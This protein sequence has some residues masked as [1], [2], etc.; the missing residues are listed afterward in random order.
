MYDFIPLS[1]CL[2]PNSQNSQKVDLKKRKSKS[3]FEY[4]TIGY[5]Q[6]INDRKSVRYG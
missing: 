1:T 2:I 6:S 4:E 5:I 3:N